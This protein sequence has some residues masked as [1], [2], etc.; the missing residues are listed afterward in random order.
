MLPGLQQRQKY[1][2]QPKGTDEELSILHEASHCS[3]LRAEQQVCGRSIWTASESLY[4][5]HYVMFMFTYSRDLSA[6]SRL[7]ITM[8]PQCTAFNYSLIDWRLPS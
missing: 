3:M 5:Y 4:M 2:A 1:H 7:M 6:G 8:S